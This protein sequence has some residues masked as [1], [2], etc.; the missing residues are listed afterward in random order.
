MHTHTHLKASSLLFPLPSHLEDREG[1]FRLHETT[2]VAA[3]PPLEAIGDQCAT[4]MGCK[5]GGEDIL[6][7]LQKDL[8]EEAYKLTIT[9]NQI[10]VRA[11][12]PT[13]SFRG[14]STLRRLAL[15]ADNI[16]PC[17]L[18]EDDASYSWRGFM[19]D[20]SR[21]MFSVA[22]IKKLID[23][24]SLF[25]LNRFHWHLTDDQGWRIPLEGYEKLETIASKRKESQYT[26][27]RTYGRLYT[28]TEILEVQAYAHEH[29]M[30]LIPE[31]E[32]PGHVSALLA[33]YP[34]LG[35]TQG[36]YTV[37][38]SWGIF[39][40]VLCAG[41]EQVFTFLEDAICQISE[42]FSDPYIH[43][44]GDECPHAAWQSCPSCQ[45][46]MQELGL[47][48]A[49]QLQAYMTSRICKL[50]EK[51]GKRPIG[52][53][54]VL[55]GTELLGL[56]KDLIVMSWRGLEGGIEASKRGHQV[57]MSP[58]TAGCYFD[59]KHLDSEE[60]MGNLGV[61]TLSDVASF[62]C[63]PPSLDA[64][65]KAHILGGQANLW[66]EKV[67]SSKQA[68]YLL[69]PRLMLMA[70]QLWNPQQRETNLTMREVLQTLC[71]KL[72]VLSYR[73]PRS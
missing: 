53:D 5:R 66:T 1:F 50:V 33:A 19:L 7:K 11:S 71:D 30:L 51:A 17:C 56:P 26:D 44:G 69:F 72:G 28:K 36:P 55:E 62:T 14:L 20:C 59:Y 32:T 31:L 37:P 6:F 22:F 12:T 35:C 46:R 63:T 9:K 10:V 38:D 29:H 43:I 42:L 21:H 8:G 68:E 45:K 25:H 4:L 39:E 67:T 48:H 61:S 34:E 24:A 13:G 49:H 58:N 16:L 40:E 65:E 15:L 41:N 73:G 2:S 57:I 52:W 60:E 64:A 3:E 23:I 47:E 70:G 18:I 27:G 54:E